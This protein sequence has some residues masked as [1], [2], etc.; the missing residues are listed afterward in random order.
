MRPFPDFYGNADVAHALAHTIHQN[1][2]PQTVLLSGPEGVGKATLARRFATALLGDGTKIERD[3]LSRPE[4]SD[5][6]EQREKWTAEKRVDAPLF[7]ATHPD[8]VTFAPDG[9]LRQI[10]IQ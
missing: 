3:D 7:I 2:I 8:F 6:I 4:N 10:T 1:R 5:T 9:P